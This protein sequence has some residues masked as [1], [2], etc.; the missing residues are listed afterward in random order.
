MATP[1]PEPTVDT[2]S[3]YKAGKRPLPY[4]LLNIPEPQWPSQ[5]PA[6][7]ADISP[8]NLEIINIPEADFQRLTWPEVRR[9]IK[10]NRI[11]EFRRAP[12]DHRNYLSYMARL[13]SEYGSVMDYVQNQRLGWTDFEAKGLAFEDPGMWVLF[14]L[15]G[16]ICWFGGERGFFLLTIGGGGCWC[17]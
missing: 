9:T 15:V 12:L 17:R 4:W 14:F 13:K 8:R 11:D 1:N 7:L 5:C 3:E 6:F 10:A 16:C 2:I